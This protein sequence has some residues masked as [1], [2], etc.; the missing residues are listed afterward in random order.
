MVISRSLRC[1]PGK[2]CAVEHQLGTRVVKDLTED[3]QGKWHHAY[4]DNFFTSHNLLVNL[5]R[6]GICGC[7]TAG[8]VR[9]GFPEELEKVKFKKRYVAHKLA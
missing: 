1:T 2:K 4:F 7:V 3:L 6:R 5:E 9:R 8:K